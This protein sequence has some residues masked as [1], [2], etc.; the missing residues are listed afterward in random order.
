M[1]DQLEQY[2]LAHYRRVLTQMD[3]DPH[4]PTYGCFDRNYWHYK[5]RD[6]P[7]SILQQG[8]FTIEAL[9]RGRLPGASAPA[10]IIDWALAAVNALSRQVNR[11]GA[12]NEYYPFEHSCPAAAFG[13]L[14]ASRVIYDWSIETPAMLCEVKWDGLRR[15]ARHLLRRVESQASN[16]QAAGLA[17][18][19]LASRVAH[20][21]VSSEK[22]ASKAAAFFA[23]Q[24]S[25][26]WFE[27]YGGPDFGY[28]SVTIDALM[29]YHEATGDPAALDA[30]H[31]AAGFLNK[32]LACDGALPSTINSRNTDYA[33]PCGII[34]LAGSSAEASWLA[35]RLFGDAAAAG[36]HFLWATDDRYH[37]H[38][39]FASVVRALDYVSAVQP[40]AAPVLSDSE[41]LPGAG[42]WIVR[43]PR[44]TVYVAAN[45][46]GLTRVHRMDKPPIADHGWRARPA[47][48]RLFTSSWWSPPASIE[49]SE[50]SIAISSTFQSFRF[51]MPTPARHAVLR[52]L[53]FPLRRRL[54]GI[55]KRMLIFRPGLGTGPSY[56][57]VV[58]V[59][60]H[61]VRIEDRFGGLGGFTLS[62]SPRQNLRH[63]ASADSFSVEEF[64]SLAEP[65]QPATQTHVREIEL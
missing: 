60:A 20:F 59:S 22:V 18:L 2:A 39:I 46:G 52:L 54:I 53:A 6:F 11:F 9:R 47:S 58:Q 42:Y 31:R 36:K 35:H 24:H 29:D 15:L 32:A 10:T 16:Q 64:D 17:A 65:V 21:E 8:V 1:K 3:R 14:A 7:S 51:R 63:V 26:G 34:R 23:T 44:S 45:K 12:V 41:W 49:R 27:E 50:D 37:S 13:L 4:S 62:R 57:R 33:V 30:C 38:Y 43:R 25:E 40:P 5:I 55:L 61:R 56:R 28:L 48:G 19:A